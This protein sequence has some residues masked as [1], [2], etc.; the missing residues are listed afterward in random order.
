MTGNKKI[1]F[2]LPENT[3]MAEIIDEILR[4][5]GIKESDEEFFNK[6]IQN[7]D[8]KFSIINDAIMTVAQKKVPE[9]NLAELLQKHLET[10]METAEKIVQ[11]IKEKTLPYIKITSAKK[12]GVEDQK[13]KYRKELLKKINANQQAPFVVV[14]EEENPPL[15]YYK[16]IEI[17]DVEKNAESMKEEGKNI[18]TEEKNKFTKRVE[19]NKEPPQNAT[20]DTYREPVE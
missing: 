12:L 1:N 20:P 8:S 6:S 15:P 7:K 14:V 13:E 3:T 16:K 19:E 18:M 2:I 9:K 17:A 4:N 10:S 11:N 5:N